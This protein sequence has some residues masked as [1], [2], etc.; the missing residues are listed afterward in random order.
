M[1]EKRPPQTQM[2]VYCNKRPATTVDHVVPLCL[3]APPLP[4]DMVTVPACQPCNVAKSKNDDYFRD[5]L[6]VDMFCV[7][8]PVAQCLL[9]GKMRRS[10][11]RN[12]S[13]VARE[14]VA[15]QRMESFYSA[16]GVYLGDVHAVKFEDARVQDIYSMMV[17]GLY[18]KILKKRLPDNYAFEIQRLYPSVA[19]QLFNQMKAVDARRV[20]MFLEM[21]S[22]A[23]SCIPPRTMA[24]PHGYCNSMEG[25]TSP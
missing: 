12:R 24:S 16:G 2:C 4:L 1:S 11:Q 9:A 17:R 18:Y 25:C 19:G 23:L 5:M 13:R 14:A 22:P 6:I 10:M 21:S 20:P 8:H 7:D 15:Q 3:F